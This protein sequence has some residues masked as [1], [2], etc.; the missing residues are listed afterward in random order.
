MPRP[1]GF[2]HLLYTRTMSANRPINNREEALRLIAENREMVKSFGVRRIGVFGS[3]V[4]G[5]HKTSSDVD[6]LVE[7]EKNTWADYCGLLNLLED[8]FGR[9]V[10]LVI[11][12]DVKEII[13]RRVLSETQYVEGF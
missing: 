1:S 13:K 7:L 4:R 6:V 10:D 5:D 8:L 11:K 12:D 3:I 9:E 2:R